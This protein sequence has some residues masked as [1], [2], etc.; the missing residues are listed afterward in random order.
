MTGRQ[1]LKPGLVI[2]ATLATLALILS[3]A[4][5]VNGPW[6]WHWPWRRL[7]WEIWPAMIAAAAPIF[8]AQYLFRRHRR[9][10]RLAV[11]LVILAL[12]TLS[13]ELTAIA[14]QPPAAPPMRRLPLLVLHK[15]ATSYYAEAVQLHN[16]TKFPLGEFLRRYPEFLPTFTLHA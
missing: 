5:G 16:A 12:G 4:H 3:H 6:Y 13:L 15:L 14:F 1:R 7:S 9:Q 2:A 8:L 11:A 10:S